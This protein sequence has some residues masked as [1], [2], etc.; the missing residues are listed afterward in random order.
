MMTWREQKIALEGAGTRPCIT[1]L[2]S[3]LPNSCSL[4]D[5]SC[6]LAAGHPSLKAQSDAMKARQAEERKTRKLQG[7]KPR[8]TNPFR[9]Y[10]AFR[11]AKK[12]KVSA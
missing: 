5:Q 8:K 9:V 2:N 1:A 11:K 3:Y 7:K 10:P 12:A 4:C 6:I